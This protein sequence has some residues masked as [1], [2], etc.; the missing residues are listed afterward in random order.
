MK[1]QTNITATLR[2]VFSQPAT[3]ATHNPI[4]G[5]TCVAINREIVMKRDKNAFRSQITGLGLLVGLFILCIGLLAG[6]KTASA[7][8]VIYSNFTPSTG[9][10]YDGGNYYTVKNSGFN[11]TYFTDTSIAVTFTMPAGP[12]YKLDKI[13]VVG[14]QTTG[15]G[16]HMHAYIETSPSL[17]T[18]DYNSASQLATSPSIVVFNAPTS[19]TKILRASNTYYLVIEVDTGAPNLSVAN[20]YKNNAGVNGTVLYLDPSSGSTTYQVLG[21]HLQYPVFRISGT[22]IPCGNPSLIQSTYGQRGSNF[23]VVAPYPSGGIAH[24]WRDNDSS[25]TWY[26]PTAVFGPA[27]QV[28]A[29]SMIESSWGNLEVVARQGAALSHYYRDYS[30]WHG[31]GVFATGASGIPSLIQNSN[32]N[33]E[34]VTPLV[35]GGVAHYYRDSSWHQTVVF[36]AGTTIDA[37]SLIQ[38]SYGGNLEVV[39]RIGSQ[40]AHFYRDFTGNWYGSAAFASGV[41]G[42]P[43]LIQGPFGSPGNFEVVTPL[44]AGGMAHYWRDNSSP[45]HPWYLSSW[46]GSGNVAGASLIHSNYGNNFEVVDRVS[47]S[48]LQHYY[49]DFHG[50]W[51]GPTTIP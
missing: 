2:S 35:S 32:G 46:F 19:P 38:S 17:R 21:T 24:Y 6:A 39:A 26:G 28:D 1:S 49:R 36:G 30:G 8:T 18:I 25:G 40:L 15:Y 34:L 37:V 3:N 4:G 44:A 12:D 51:N 27:G 13:E 43:S 29:V 33:F 10:G 48:T 50:V 31:T 20:W 47:C 22:P 11:G 23:E 45:N 42:A 9:S 5:A 41:S 16:S 14:S 7:S